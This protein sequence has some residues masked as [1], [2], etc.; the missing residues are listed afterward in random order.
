MA[1]FLLEEYLVIM[2]R[3]YPHT[4]YKVFFFLCA[5]DNCLL[6]PCCQH[7]LAT[8]SVSKNQKAGVDKWAF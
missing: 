5:L 8:V 2:A 3:T 1:L 4:P 6:L 7:I